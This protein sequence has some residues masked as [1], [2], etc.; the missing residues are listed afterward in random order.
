MS[1]HYKELRQKYE[2]SLDTMWALFKFGREREQAMEA[3]LNQIKIICERTSTDSR[4]RLDEILEV[5][6]DD[7]NGVAV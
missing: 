6:A 4:D 5:L 2:H 1:N 3:K 7:R